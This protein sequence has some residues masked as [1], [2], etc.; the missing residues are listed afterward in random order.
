VS[1]L[2][3]RLEKAKRR[4]SGA[5]V[6][7]G[8]AAEGGS[9]ERESA[10]EEVR[11]ARDAARG[12]AEELAGEVTRLRAE[13]AEKPVE[14]VPD[15]DPVIEEL[16]Q[17]RDAAGAELAAARESLEET[18]KKRS[19]LEKKLETQNLLYV[20]LRSELEAKKDRLRTQ[21]ELI[22]RLQALEVSL[23]S[24]GSSVASGE[25]QP[26]PSPMGEGGE[27]AAAV[28][29]ELPKGEESPEAQG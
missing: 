28:E 1:S 18:K 22:E 21:Q 20:S 23:G 8:P 15:E 24:A 14:V 9:L 4:A 5:R 11:Q 26:E 6:P 2:R 27:E 13:L 7:G 29:A 19:R 12:E 17:A 10:L 16:R 25:A 3:K